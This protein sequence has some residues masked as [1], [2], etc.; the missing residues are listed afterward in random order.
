MC[1]L[2]VES[3]MPR[4]EKFNRG[5][6]YSKQELGLE[7][8]WGAEGLTMLEWSPAGMVYFLVTEHVEYI[9]LGFPMKDDILRSQLVQFYIAL[10]ILSPYIVGGNM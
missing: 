9:G 6:E 10:G 2:S 8:T 3:D 1:S 5:N 7:Q 4:N